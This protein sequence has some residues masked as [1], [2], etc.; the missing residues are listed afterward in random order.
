MFLSSAMTMHCSMSIVITSSR[1][2]KS[3]V[4]AEAA[5]RGRKILGPGMSLAV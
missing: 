1:R 5:S 4:E 3:Q 2:N